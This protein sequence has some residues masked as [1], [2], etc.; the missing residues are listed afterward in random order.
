MPASSAQ[1]QALPLGSDK[2]SLDVV[3]SAEIALAFHASLSGLSRA[4]IL[5]FATL[6]PCETH[7]FCCNMLGPVML[8]VDESEDA[9]ADEPA[10]DE[11]DEDFGT[12]A[13]S[14]PRSA[15]RSGSRQPSRRA[16]V[17]FSTH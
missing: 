4:V 11:D 16:Q 1:P 8:A 17:L 5:L 3:S 15:G 10:D 13:P 7:L 12:R 2:Q 14:R 9:S 6:A